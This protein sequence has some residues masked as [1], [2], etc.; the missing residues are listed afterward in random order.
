MLVLHVHT[1]SLFTRAKVKVMKQIRPW[2]RTGFARNNHFS[3]QLL[4]RMNASCPQSAQESTPAGGGSFLT[5]SYIRR[6]YSILVVKT[7]RSIYNI[8]FSGQ[9]DPPCGLLSIVNCRRTG[10]LVD[11]QQTSRI[12]R[13]IMKEANI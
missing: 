11:Q 5:Q 8:L 7:Q 1:R 9:Q 12:G 3:A 2:T 6:L 4:I 13:D 10:I